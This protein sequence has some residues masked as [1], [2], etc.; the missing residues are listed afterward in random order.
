M[1]EYFPSMNEALGSIPG[2]EGR[3]GLQGSYELKMCIVFSLTVQL[4][5]VLLFDIRVAF[6]SFEVNLEKLKFK[7]KFN[8]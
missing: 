1:V 2:R 8:C 7:F 6:K 4:F 5:P 3:G